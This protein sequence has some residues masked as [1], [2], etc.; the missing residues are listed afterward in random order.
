MLVEQFFQL[1]FPSQMKVFNQ[2]ARFLISR[3]QQRCIVGLYELDKSLIELWVDRHQ[4]EVIG[5]RAVSRSSQLYRYVEDI[6]LA[7]FDC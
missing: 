5:F 7:L 3:E 1:S 2:R 6:P 4:N